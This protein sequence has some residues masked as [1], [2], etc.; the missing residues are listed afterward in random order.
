MRHATWVLCL[1]LGCTP[2]PRGA[3]SEPADP[4]VPP[5][6]ST[7]A[8]PSPEPSAAP[9]ALPP[10]EV[11]DPGPPV[12][13]KA[14]GTKTVRATAGAIVAVDP[15]AARLGARVLE[16]GGNAV[17]AAVAV[18]F[19]LAVTHPSAGNIGGGG[20]MLVRPKAGPTT[21]ID[22][23]ETAPA[24]LPRD[25]FDAMIASDGIGPV[26][27]GVPGTVRGLALAHQKFGK[28]PWAKLVEPA[29]RLA[30]RGHRI[31]SREAQTI[32]WSWALLKKDP[33]AAAE[34]GD[35]KGPR[36]E[37]DTLI[38]KDLAIT[39]GRIA[40]RGAAGFYE[41][42]TARAIVRTLAKR[43][44]TLTLDDLAKYEAK[45]RPPLELAYRGLTL[46]TMPPPSAGGVALLQI[47]GMLERGRAYRLGPGSVES[48]HL[49]LEASRRAQADKR[50]GVVDPDALPEA[51][52]ALRLA[53]FRDVRGLLARLPIEPRRPTPSEKVHPLYGAALRELEHT[54]HFSVVDAEGMAVSCTTTLSAG[55]GSKIVVPG[56]GVVLNNAVAS[57]ASAGENLP[58][59]GRRTVSSMT[60]T[61]VTKEGALWAVLGSPGGD[62]IPSTVAQVFLNLVDHGM[63][64]DRAVEA[65]RIHHNFV[66][67]EV[68]YERARPPPKATLDG[69]KQLGHTLGKKTLPMGDANNIVLV[70]GVAYAMADP[71]EG[72]AAV[73]AR[74]KPG[75]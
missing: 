13:L 41:G 32:A 50:F 51:E 54:T 27:V 9:A 72:G 16:D 47:L 48:A 37:K 39:L 4:P 58:V 63:T 55:F 23:R 21:A 74:R 25:A 15:E 8:A 19:V 3:P 64:L 70:D 56:T 12:A 42:E 44:G 2:A 53:R 24:S 10:P 18:A 20:F 71:R 68:R 40:E 33:A 46:E 14:G 69:L 34:F 62:T 29:K 36:K 57:F 31:R 7:S 43:G 45:L 22:F 5:A 73:A 6:P 61:L 35:G 67:D 60:P 66:P 65:G 11:L 49:F 1:V 30:E 75:P 38:R 26:S 28:L 59:G 52:Q 17:D